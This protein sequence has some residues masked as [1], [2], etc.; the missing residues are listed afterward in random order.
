[1]EERRFCSLSFFSFPSSASFVSSWFNHPLWAGHCEPGGGA[2]GE[3]DGAAFLD[4]AAGERVEEGPA[5]PLRQD[6]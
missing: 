6:A 4:G 5:I 2:G 1:M 3:I